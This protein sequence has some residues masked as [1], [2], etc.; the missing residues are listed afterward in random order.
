MIK[1]EVVF[2]DS[3]MFC[4][5]LELW[6]NNDGTWVVLDDISQNFISLKEAIAYCMEKFNA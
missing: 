2:N 5:G 4:N 6:E 1:A 3:G